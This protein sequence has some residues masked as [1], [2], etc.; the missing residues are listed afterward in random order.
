MKLNDD[1]GSAFR[2]AVGF[3][4]AAAVEVESEGETA[5]AVG[6]C[7]GLLARIDLAAEYALA[8]IVAAQ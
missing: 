2:R 5:K 4:P 6:F 7:A 3:F 1:F 8:R